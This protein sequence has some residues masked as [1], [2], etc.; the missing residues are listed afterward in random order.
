[1]RYSIKYSLGTY[2]LKVYSSNQRLSTETLQPSTYQQIINRTSLSLIYSEMRVQTARTQLLIRFYYA[3]LI[4]ATTSRS[5]GN[6]STLS[7]WSRVSHRAA[8]C[9]NKVGSPFSKSTPIAMHR[10]MKLRIIILDRY[11]PTLHLDFDCQFFKDFP[12]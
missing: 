3:C 1:M 5:A 7:N 9:S 2:A 8:S 6:Q 10:Q 12:T 4:A 11:Q